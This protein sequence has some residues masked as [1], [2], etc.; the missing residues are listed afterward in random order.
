MSSRTRNSAR[1]IL[2]SQ[3]AYAAVLILQFVSRSIFIRL[4]P[5]EYLGLNGLFSNV[6]S[7]LSLAELGIGSAVDFALY[8]PLKENDVESLKS[9]LTLYRRLYWITGAVILTA[10]AIL[11]PFL[12]CLIKDMP[13]NM[14]HMYLYFILYLLH[15]GIPYFFAYKRSLII[16]DQKEYISTALTALFNILLKVLQIA[17]LVVSRNYALYLSATVVTALL[18]NL[19]ISVLA[20]RMYPYLK[21]K[22][23]RKLPS[24]TGKEIRKRV[25]ALVFRKIGTI[26]VYATDNIII[27]RFVG[28][29]S[30]GIY[31]NYTLVIQAVQMAAYRFFDSINASIGNLTVSSEKGYV[32]KVLYRILFAN[33]WMFSFCSAALLSL[34]QPFIRLWA[35]PEYLLPGGTLLVIIIQF[36]LEG[37]RATGVTFRRVL[38]LYWPARYAPVIEGILN[39]A[40]SIP[41]AVRFG[42]SGTLLGTIISTSCVSAIADPYVLF[43]YYFRKNMNH[44]MLKFFLEQAKYTASAAATAFLTMILC[45]LVTPDP[46]SGFILRL[47]LCILTPNLCMAFIF[48][49][50][51]HYIYY[52]RFAANI[53]RSR[54]R[55]R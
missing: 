18:E 33:A 30:V 26:I 43:R 1:N 34:F 55:S 39:L 38:G 40:L 25:Y 4:L 23:V 16:C 51:E 47:C 11:T 44:G 7:L 22:N 8:R 14:E 19:I 28:F 12:P 52:K 53:W 2:F 48:R 41:L 42:I 36:Y 32:E 29:F 37:M 20:D 15:S 46:A 35:G 50:N 49:K 17:I 54:R 10:G 3:I 31:S 24:E 9:I 6:L 5:V 13:D 27:S 21:D 45:R